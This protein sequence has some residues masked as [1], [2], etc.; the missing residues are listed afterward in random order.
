MR[1]ARN[2]VALPCGFTICRRRSAQLSRALEASQ[3]QNLSCHLFLAAMGANVI[4]TRRGTKEAARRNRPAD[5]TPY[6]R[7][8]ARLM[9]LRREENVASCAHIS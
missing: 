6:N 5:G 9:K 8:T 3:L 4:S 2:V 1:A 7:P